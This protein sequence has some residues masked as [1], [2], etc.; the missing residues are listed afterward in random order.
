VRACA[1]S[2]EDPHLQPRR[3]I[4]TPRRV[5]NPSYSVTVNDDFAATK[6]SQAA[7][8]KDAQRMVP[9]QPATGIKAF[10]KQAIADLNSQNPIVAAE[11]DWTYN[12]EDNQTMGAAVAERRRSNDI[13]SVRQQLLKKESQKGRRRPGES[14]PPL[15]MGD[16]APGVQ[17]TQASPRMATFDEEAQTGMPTTYPPP[18]QYSIFPSQSRSPPGSSNNNLANI[19]GNPH[20][21][22]SQPVPPGQRAR[23][24]S[25]S[26]GPQQGPPPAGFR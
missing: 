23:G 16:N 5:N 7:K 8:S 22:Q 1:C 11:D 20:P 24:Q 15:A 2:Q 6:R 3:W 17:L 10:E 12:R 21:L 18:T 9:S 19:Q 25:L 14:L 13:E 4:R 26:R